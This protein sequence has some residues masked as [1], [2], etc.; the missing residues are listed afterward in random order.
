MQGAINLQ[1]ITSRVVTTPFGSWTVQSTQ[2]YQWLF[3]LFK[4]ICDATD[5]QFQGIRTA[6]CNPLPTI[7]YQVRTETPFG[8]IYVRPPYDPDVV[9][10]ATILHQLADGL[11]RGFSAPPAILGSPIFDGPAPP[12]PIAATSLSPAL[13]AKLSALSAASG[14]F[15][16][17]AHP[18]PVLNGGDPILQFPQLKLYEVSGG[19]SHPQSYTELVAQVQVCLA[20]G[21]IVVGFGPQSDY[22]QDLG[23]NI[24]VP[25]GYHATPAATTHADGQPWQASDFTQIVSD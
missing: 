16:L 4:K 2:L 15:V 11:D 19:Q 1:P 6:Y 3:P 23:A 7:P 20:A 5:Q 13:T 21:S 8:P 10:L 17:F 14:P 12:L 24:T 22:H 18:A 9:A 25:N